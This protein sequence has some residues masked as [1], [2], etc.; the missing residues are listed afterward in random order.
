MTLLF[1]VCLY[2]R[3]RAR[4]LIQALESVCVQ[5]L[6]PEQ[7]EVIVVDNGSTD[8]TRSVVEGFTGRIHNL[9][10]F[11]EARAGSGRARNRGWQEAIGE[12][13]AFIDDDGKAPANWL[14]VAAQVFTDYAPDLFGGP[15]QPFYQT[16]KPKWFKDQYGVLS[17]GGAARWL[18]SQDEYLYGSNL[19]V[20]RGVLLALG[21]FDE[22]LGMK[23]SRIGYG[24]ETV[25]IRSARHLSPAIRIYYEPELVAYHLVRPEKMRFVWQLRHR[26]AQGRDGYHIFNDGTQRM[27]AR[28]AM[29]LMAVPVVIALESTLG[30]LVRDRQAYPYVQNYYYERVLQRVATMGKL[31]ERLR[32]SLG[33]RSRTDD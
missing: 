26:F 21:G 29:G 23:G 11:Y 28:H 12:V 15:I 31:Y 6:P 3:N 9:R 30:V 13:A 10:Y 27:T 18:V 7:Y 25:L 4:L 32:C 5:T 8:D 22:R 20:R 16:S 17:T 24:E 2:T 1:S 19:F 33:L 14:R